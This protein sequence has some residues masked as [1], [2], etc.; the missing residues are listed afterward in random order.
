MKTATAFAGATSS[1]MKP[2]FTHSDGRYFLVAADG[3]IELTIDRVRRDRHQLVG[4]LDVRCFLKGAQ[5]FADGRLLITTITLSNV[6]ARD[7]VAKTIALRAGLELRVVSM[8][9]EDFT[10]RIWAAER[11][12]TPAVALHELAPEP[13]DTRTRYVHGFRLS[14]AHPQI[15]FGAPGTGKSLLDL[16]IAGELGRQGIHTLVCDYEADAE[17]QRAR[18]HAL[19]LPPTV[20]Y[21]YCDRPFVVLADEIRR[22]CDEKNIGFLIVD[23][24]APACQGDANDAQ[25]AND[26]FNAWRRVGRGGI[27][28]AHTRKEDGEKAPFGSRFFE[29]RARA[30]WFLKRVE[31]AADP[32]TMTL[33]VFNQKVNAGPKQAP[34]GLSITC[35]GEP[36][37]PE[38]LRRVTVQRTDIAS[39][40][41][42]ANEL[43]LWMR[44]KGL[45]AQGPRKIVE[46][47]EALDEKPN[48]ISQ[49]LSRGS[50]PDRKGG[51]V[52]VLLP[53]SDDGVQRWALAERRVPHA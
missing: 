39:V 25:T 9:I 17:E 42:L 51:Q 44:I 29:A 7:S 34:F 13:Q 4:E 22:E 15:V 10:Q 3:L 49:A 28:I 43:P 47:A 30:T 8:L 19:Q 38:V 26:L 53:R 24:I 5:T 20:W 52:F 45:L 27:A 23:S 35:E 21:R 41:S 33:G 2:T 37:A 32:N 48:S 50:D 14:L 31:P 11:T 18:G 6:T 16:A 46:M 12:G 40:P 36:N 1:E